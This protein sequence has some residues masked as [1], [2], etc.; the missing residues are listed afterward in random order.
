MID[1][2]RVRDVALIRE[3]KMYPCA[4]LTVLTGET[5]AGKT[6]L[7]SACKL[8]MGQRGDK[9][10]VREGAEEAQVE[11]RFYIPSS[12]VTQND[13]FSPFSEDDNSEEQA[14]DVSEQNVAVANDDVV[15][16][17]I[18][19]NDTVVQHA[20]AANDA[21]AA[22]ANEPDS[23]VNVPAARNAAEETEVVV[24][25]RLSADGRSR[26]SVN[27]ALSSVTQ[28]S[29]LIA[30]TVDLC[31]QNEHQ[32]LLHPANHGALLDAWARDKIT[33]ARTSYK[34]AYQQA[35]D[36]ASEWDL[37]QEASL[38]SRAA[39]DEARFT[40]RQ[41]DSVS[42]AEGEYEELVAYLEKTENAE[43]L[44]RASHGAH[45]AL[46]GESGALDSLNAATEA[47]TEGA[48][49]DDTL[50]EYAQTLREAGY[51][52]EDVARDVATYRDN[53]DFDADELARAQERVSA[54][55][56]LMRNYGPTLEDVF[57]RRSQAYEIVSAVDNNEERQKAAKARLD[58]AEEKLAETAHELHEARAA[59]APRFAEAVSS[60][61]SRLRMG[62][63]EL[64]CEVE[65]L[66]RS[67]WTESGP[68]S[69][70][71]FFRPAQGM[72]PRP[73]ARIASGGE[74]SRV[75]LAIHVV[76]GD[77]DNVET[78]V[79]DEVDAG[80]GGNVAHA[81]AD[82]LADVAKTHQVI[83]VTHLAQVAARAD[84]HYVVE[85][86][87]DVIPETKLYKVSDLE[88]IGEIARMLSGSATEASL[89]HAAE[90]LEEASKASP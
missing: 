65:F 10:I 70:E 16:H 39:L 17:A 34:A 79:F 33:A 63:A 60:V 11:G 40:L 12:L 76:L 4:G 36:A 71:F 72:Q 35:R 3:A 9:T 81:L 13:M 1:E 51:V 26:V 61:M 83:V 46:A 31:G 75:M 37:M 86:S 87:R 47:L 45:E 53:I 56:G 80:V 77:A 69:V 42:P 64:L 38:T 21:A 41:I 44:A 2:I 49:F 6:A 82:V 68:S 5:G 59:A 8:L 84:V 85:K 90:L 54:I 23:E 14:F 15:Q 7:L 62:T 89:A 66:E 78:L 30:P 25:R 57:A 48:R 28:L 19:A 74:I 43:S 22:A 88:R 29:D 24:T 27:G 32:T 58:A 18:A 50:S 55:Q 20:A 67:S 73:L 52:L